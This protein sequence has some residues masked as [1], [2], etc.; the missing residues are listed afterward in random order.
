[1][2]HFGLFVFGFSNLTF[3]LGIFLT[4]LSTFLLFSVLELE[5]IVLRRVIH[6][7]ILD[8]IWWYCSSLR[9]I[10]CNMCLELGMKNF[11]SKCHGNTGCSAVKEVLWQVQILR[12]RSLLNCL[13]LCECEF[14]FLLPG[15]TVEV[16]TGGQL[17]ILLKSNSNNPSFFLTHLLIQLDRSG[18][19]LLNPCSLGV[20]NS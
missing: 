16:L 3:S 12:S 5:K 13:R 9:N 4:C 15:L 7:F 18:C 10:S 17:F 8:K 6:S 14:P 11:C 19:L 2:T 1:M 20:A